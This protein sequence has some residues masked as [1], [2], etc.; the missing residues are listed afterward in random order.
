MNNK[1]L[2]WWFRGHWC[3]KDPELF[4]ALPPADVKLTCID[5]NACRGCENWESPPPNGHHAANLLCKHTHQ[6]CDWCSNRF[7]SR[8]HARSE[9]ISIQI[10]R[11]RWI[12]F[13]CKCVVEWEWVMQE[14]HHYVQRIY[15]PRHSWKINYNRESDIDITILH[16]F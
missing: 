4:A 14:Q 6:A 3:E 7:S 11:W 8:P 9:I 12:K 5:L 16:A 1:K 13:R 10:G 2:P 15:K